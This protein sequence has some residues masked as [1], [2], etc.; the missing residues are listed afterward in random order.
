MMRPLLCAISC[1][2][3]TACGDVERAAD[4]PAHEPL[5]PFGEAG[6]VPEVEPIDIEVFSREDI[7]EPS[8]GRLVLHILV[9]GEAGTEQ[10]RQTI[11][12]HLTEEGE[13]DKSLLAI[14]AVVYVIPRD[15][16]GNL[17]PVAWAEWAPLQGW[18]AVRRR[19]E[20]DFYR[21]K[22]FFGVDPEWR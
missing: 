18:D 19:S 6:D 13:K 14:R 4:R 16:S 9:P 15:G 20:D 1:M 3:L 8:P 17:V 11:V 22:M 7:D 12:R 21:T 2:L 5:I 10:V